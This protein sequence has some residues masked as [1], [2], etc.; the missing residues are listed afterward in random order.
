[1]T[2]GQAHLLEDVISLVGF[3]LI[4]PMTH[5]EDVRMQLQLDPEEG[6]AVFERLTLTYGLGDQHG[7]FQALQEAILE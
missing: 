7:L 2:I 3:S 6:P 1:M 4:V 5:F